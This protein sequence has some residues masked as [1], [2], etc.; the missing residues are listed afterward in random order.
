MTQIFICGMAHVLLHLPNLLMHSISI[1]IKPTYA[2]YTVYMGIATY[3]N[4]S[5]MQTKTVAKNTKLYWS[6]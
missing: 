3:R 4:L 2:M 6:I 5:F 1:F